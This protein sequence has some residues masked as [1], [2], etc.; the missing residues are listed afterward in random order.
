LQKLLT[1]K[2]TRNYIIYNKCPHLL[3]YS[4][5]SYLYQN[6]PLFSL[7]AALDTMGKVSGHSIHMQHEEHGQIH[8]QD[9]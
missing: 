3:L 9:N 4:V 2:A 8:H 7:C 5:A 1:S 6:F